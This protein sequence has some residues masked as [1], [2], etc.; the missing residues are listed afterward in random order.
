VADWQI[1]QYGT[2]NPETWIDGT[3]YAGLMAAHAA[4]QQPRFAD[5][6]TAW[7]QANKWSMGGDQ[8]PDW[9]GAGQ[10]FLELYQGDPVAAHLAPTQKVVDGVVKAAQPG[11]KVWWW[12]DALF[13][14]PPVFA[15]LG[16]ATAQDSYF[17]T[18]STM[19]WDVTSALYDSSA[20]LFFRDASY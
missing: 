15:R 9:E 16:A 20:G 18:M 8:S 17:A 2:Q 7:A 12:A 1:A 19:W 13:M 6:A 3:F 14:A 5:R 10:T 11:R 4:T